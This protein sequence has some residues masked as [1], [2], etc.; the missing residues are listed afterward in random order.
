MDHDSI[1]RGAN[2]PVRR[3]VTES[4]LLPTM[5]RA[6]RAGGLVAR[7]HFGRRVEGREE[8]SPAPF[9]VSLA[10]WRDGQPLAAA[11]HDPLSGE[12]F[13]ALRGGGAR[14]NGRVLAVSGAGSLRRAL[15]ATGWA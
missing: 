6:V 2:M 3:P 12:L 14:R 1:G 11:V 13:T 15:V 9:A 10:F 5:V 4:R 8:T 7:R